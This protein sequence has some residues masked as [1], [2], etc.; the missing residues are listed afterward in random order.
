M[1][2]SSSVAAGVHPCG[3]C[4]VRPLTV[5]AVLDDEEIGRL[6]DLAQT[7]R[8][9]SNQTIFSEGDM[10]SG[11]FNVTSG[12]VKVYKLLQD[13]RRQITGF[14]FGG[15]FMGLS[16]HD[17]YVYSAE[18]VSSTTMCRFPRRQLDRLMDEFPKLQRQL[19]SL[20]SS[21]LA[22][23]QDQMLLLG[24]K[25]AREKIASFLMMLSR[26]AVARGQT[27]NPV[28]VPMG[29]ADIADYLGLTTET[30]SRTVTQLKSAGLIRLIEGN[31]IEIVDLDRIL[32]IADGS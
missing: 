2:R 5:C 22:A 23:A 25:T 19:F 7:Q 27:D 28:S 20:A 4:T 31:K 12:T 21:E 13:G 10:A 32:E 17:R 30:V 26:R 18:S 8:V 9:E 11:V 14:L 1:A 29:R 15:D 24:R 6:A 3:V 16:T